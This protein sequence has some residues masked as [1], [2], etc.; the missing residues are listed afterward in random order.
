VFVPEPRGEGDMGGKERREDADDAKLEERD[1][2]E[3]KLHLRAWGQISL[4][5]IWCGWRR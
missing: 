2:N 3:W 1:H 5:W 4:V